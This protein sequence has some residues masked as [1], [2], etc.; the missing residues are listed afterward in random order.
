MKKMK[1]ASV[2][3]A[4][5]SLLNLQPALAQSR[6]GAMTITPSIGYDFFAGRR[7]LQNTAVIPEIAIGYNFSQV[8]GIE[9]AY[10]MF[11]THYSHDNHHSVKGNLY[12]VDGIY[13]FAARGMVEPFVSAGVG[14]IYQHPHYNE[15]TNQGNINAGVGTNIF[16]GNSIALRPE[17]R[18]IYTIS[19]GKNDLLLNLGVSFLVGG[20]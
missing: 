10:G 16:F 19:G 6:A 7:H 20:N 2:V 5:M 12:T 11:N 3:L 8:W 4:G 1:L 9:A 18:D 14:L 17:V 15:A 13:R